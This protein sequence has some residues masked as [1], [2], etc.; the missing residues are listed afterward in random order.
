MPGNLSQIIECLLFVAGEPLPARDLARTVESD[1]EAVHAAVRELRDRYAHSGL[2][3]VE[4]AGGFQMATRP[5]FAGAVGRLLAPHAN[6]LSRPAL[7]TAA[8]IA[9]R[10][11]CTAADIEA[12]RG[13]ASAGFNATRLPAAI[14]STA[15][16]RASC[17]G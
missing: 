1:A 15:G 10:Q 16:S 7:E 9:Y 14:A 11:P 5:E 17:T 13:V 2:Q 6:R 3:V 4:I 8:I 12:V